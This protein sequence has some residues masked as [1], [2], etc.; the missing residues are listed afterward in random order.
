M[1]ICFKSSS[2]DCVSSQEQSPWLVFLDSLD[3]RKAKNWK[4][5]KY[6]CTFFV[7]WPTATRNQEPKSLQA[8]AASTA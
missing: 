1:I 4:N 5:K 3:N 6:A 7:S 8:E 2:Q